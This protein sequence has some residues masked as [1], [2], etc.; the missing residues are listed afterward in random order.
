MFPRLRKLNIGKETRAP[1]GLVT[2]EMEIGVT[3]RMY[4][5]LLLLRIFFLLEGHNMGRYFDSYGVRRAGSKMQHLQA[6]PRHLDTHEPIEEGR[7]RTFQWHEVYVS[8]I[9]S[10]SANH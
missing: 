3:R 7:D 10:R 6:M 2:E 9:V 8:S 1:L 5:F 4:R